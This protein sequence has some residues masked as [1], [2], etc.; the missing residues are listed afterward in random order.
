MSKPFKV[1]V[2]LARAQH[3]HRGHEFIIDT[4]LEVC[5]KVLIFV[6]S[7]QKGGPDEEDKRNPFSVELRIQL[8]KDIYAA[9]GDR[10]IV[11]GLP[12]LTTEDDISKAWGLY[13]LHHMD[14][15]SPGGL[16]DIQLMIYGNDEHR[17]GWFDFD[18]ARELSSHIHQ[19]AIARGSEVDISSTQLRKY[20]LADDFSNWSK[21]VNPVLFP[22]FVQIRNELLST[23]AYEGE[24]E[25]L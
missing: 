22:R 12:D 8:I 4:A 10:V 13:L 16:K 23:K 15:H 11:V 5:E 24:E 21:Y 20:I 7:A 3:I 14:I 1:G 19:L 18:E 25:Q 17:F 9:Y 6:G 2:F